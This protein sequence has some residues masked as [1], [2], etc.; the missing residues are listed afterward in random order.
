M[1]YPRFCFVCGEDQD[2]CNGNI[3]YAERLVLTGVH[4]CCDHLGNMRITAYSSASSSWFKAAP[5]IR[6]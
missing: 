3:A 4:E 5:L 1:N 6:S 2:V